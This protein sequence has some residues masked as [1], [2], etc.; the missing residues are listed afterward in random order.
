MIINDDFIDSLGTNLSQFSK[1]VKPKLFLKDSIYYKIWD[2]SS[3]PFFIV[4][5]LDLIW[6]GHDTIAPIS[7][8]IINQETCPAFKELL[9]NNEEVCVGYSMYEGRVIENTDSRYDNFTNLL[10]DCSLNQGYCFN[11]ASWWNIVDYKGKLSLIDIDFPPAKIYHNKTLSE[12]EKKRWDYIVDCNN[13]S[14][15]FLGLK[16]KL[17]QKPS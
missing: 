6:Q 9:F 15:Y 2:T 7:V 3:H 14:K 16:E 17:A 10:I 12:T 8:G 1:K 13:Q 11:D 5:G 4:D